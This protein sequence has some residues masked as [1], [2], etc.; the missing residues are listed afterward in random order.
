MRNIIILRARNAA[1][2]E[3][4]AGV[5]HNFHFDV[6][7]PTNVQ[8]FIDGVKVSPVQPVP[9]TRDRQRPTLRRCK[10]IAASSE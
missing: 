3:L 2:G 8:F 6:T 1:T 7:D 5:F 10:S 4:V 9:S